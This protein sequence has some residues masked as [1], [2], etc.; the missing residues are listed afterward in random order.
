MYTTSGEWFHKK[1]FKIIKST[2]VSYKN[3][4]FLIK[5]KKKL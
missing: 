2:K 3:K 1:K 4:I 5:L